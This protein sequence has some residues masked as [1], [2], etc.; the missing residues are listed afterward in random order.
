M[1]SRLRLLL[2]ATVVLVMIVVIW[3]AVVRITGSGIS[4]PDWPLIGGSLLPPFDDEGWKSVYQS[5]RQESLRLGNPIY[6]SDLPL[7]V[8]KRQFWIEYIHRGLAA[9]VGLFLIAFLAIGYRYPETAP[10]IKRRGVLLV[11]LLLAQAG[12]GGVVV[13]S[14][15]H[16]LL[17]AV[18]LLMAYIFSGLLL[19]MLLDL[20][21]KRAPY[22]GESSSVGL[23]PLTWI[24]WGLG[25]LLVQVF[26]GGWVAGLNAGSVSS[27]WPTM[28]GSLVPPLSLWGEVSILVHFL[29]RWWGFIPFLTYLG[30]FISLSYVP[31]AVH[32]RFVLI[33]VGALI[34]LQVLLGIINVLTGITPFLAGLHS[35]VAFLIYSGQLYLFHQ[36]RYNYLWLPAQPAIQSETA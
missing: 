16:G 12:L 1:I 2:G 33:A 25:A 19:T 14:G 17:V 9:L 30:L 34:T 28:F 18:H 26:L 7:E 29:H 10:A 6:P 23:V 4:I 11:T 32:L 20:S 24:R 5:Y 31:L 35:G 3:G 22:P 21:P 27:T 13:K 8:F 36:L 15:L